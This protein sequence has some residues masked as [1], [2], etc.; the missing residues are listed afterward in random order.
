[1]YGGIGAGANVNGDGANVNGDGERRRAG[2]RC[3]SVGVR[4]SAVCRGGGECYLFGVDNIAVHRGEF[5]TENGDG[6]RR[7][8]CVPFLSLPHPQIRSPT[9]ATV[10][11]SVPNNRGEN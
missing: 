1:M 6:K 3:L 5:Y 2:V 10:L 4:L 8:V 11:G 7:T 9:S